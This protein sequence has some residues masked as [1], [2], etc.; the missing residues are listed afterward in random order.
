M[1]EIYYY[2][3]DSKHMIRILTFISFGYQKDE[4]INMYDETVIHNNRFIE[5]FNEAVNN[6][7]T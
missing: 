6:V 2:L 4:I 5:I 7:N 1:Y 3:M